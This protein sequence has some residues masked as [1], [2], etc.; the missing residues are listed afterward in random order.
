MKTALFLMAALLVSCS[1]TSSSTPA[2]SSASEPTT[3]SVAAE[4]RTMIWNGVAVEGGRVFVSGPLWTGS[5]GPSVAVL[6]KAGQPQPYPDAAW[7]EAG[8]NPAQSF[9]NVNAIHRDGQGHLWVIDAGVSGFGGPPVPSGPKAV[10]IDLGTNEVVRVYPFDARVAGPGSYVDD[11]RF[12]GRRGYL[13][14]AGRPGIIVLDLDSG[15]AR[16]VL[17]GHPSVTAPSNRPVVVDGQIVRAPDGSPLCVNA[18]PLEVSPD[19][20]Y[21]YYA[22]LHGPWSRIETRWLD[23]ASL[24][25]ADLAAKV[26]PWAD[27]PPTGGTAMMANGDLY[28]GDLAANAIKRRAADGTITT[29]IQD[30]RLHWVDAPDIDADGFIWLPTPQMDRVALFQG[31]T[32]KIE[33]PVRLYRLRIK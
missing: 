19:G 20:K 4:S 18:D 32:A 21:L 29:V 1:S 12:H 13:T 28:F 6:D 23:D 22:P 7:N 24:N 27:L 10:E 5:K 11:I 8:R 2:A 26:E 31:G 15:A 3:L 30:A 17:D 25:P 14:D 33:L 16:R 9:V